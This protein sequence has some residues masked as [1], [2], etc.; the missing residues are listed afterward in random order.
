MVDSDI[1]HESLGYSELL[2]ALKKTRT[3]TLHPISGL[4][5]YRTLLSDFCVFIANLNRVKI[6][7]NIHEALEIPL[8]E[9]NCYGI[10]KSS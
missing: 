8:V 4:V 2:I 10:N 9:R 1:H 7:K 3:F 5:S 6:P